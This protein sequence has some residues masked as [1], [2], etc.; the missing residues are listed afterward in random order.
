L[1]L[2]SIAMRIPTSSRLFVAALAG[3][4]APVWAHEGHG[5]WGSHWHATDVLGFAVV[6]ALAFGAWVIGRRK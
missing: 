3:L 6:I 5:L 1:N 4:H 2:E